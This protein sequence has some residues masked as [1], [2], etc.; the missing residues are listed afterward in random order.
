MSKILTPDE[1]RA[2]ARHIYELVPEIIPTEINRTLVSEWAEKNR[3]LTEGPFQG[4]FTFEYT[5]YLVEIA[6][7]LSPSCEEVREV[8]FMKP[9]RIGATVSVGENWIGATID[10]FPCDMGYI[11]S[12]GAMAEIQMQT[13][14]DALINESGIAHKIGETKKRAGQKKSG[15]KTVLKQFPSGSLLAGGPNSSFFKRS[16]GFKFLNVTEV[17]GFADDIGKEGDP[18]GLFRRRCGAFQNDYKILWES[19]PKLDHNSKIKRLYNEG[20]KRKF[21]VPCK[22]CGHEQ[23]LKWGD[24]DKP[25]GLKFEKDDDDR[26]IEGSV[27][28]E[29]EEC[30]G[31]W[32]NSDKDY[33]LKRGYWKATAV[34]RKP[35]VR[36]Y[37]INALYSPI[38]FVSWETGVMEFLEIKHNGFPALEFQ[39][40]VN[41]FLGEPFEDRGERPKIE[42]VMSRKKDYHVDTLPEWADPLF[43]TLGADVQKDRIEC[44]IVAWC[45]DF[46]SF[47]IN[48]HVIPGEA[49]NIND[50]CWDKLKQI[51]EAE[52][53]GMKIS[54][55]GIDSGYETN[56]VYSFCD[57]FARG[58]YP[59]MGSEQRTKDREVIKFFTIQGF[60]CPRVDINTVR[61]KDDLYMNLA[62]GMRE[63]GSFPAGYMHF[64]IEYDRKYFNMLTAENVVFDQKTKKKKYIAG[65]RRNESTDTRVYN[66]SLVHAYRQAI[67]DQLK[68]EEKME[69]DERLVFDN[70]WLYIK[71]K[72]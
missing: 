18:I 22:H 33:F 67:E 26:L 8:A 36:S 42:A 11:T 56:T 45:K 40:W 62:K 52:H 63:D 5:P 58:V 65:S 19:S 20:D 68:A 50:E 35:H 69:E 54:L 2:A 49:K 13:R 10:A 1:I 27:Y 70:F 53:C 14:I 59:V 25:G 55:S 60:N 3:T 72:K 61:L 30:G 46:E 7:S 9:A 29:C 15:D 17:D 28:Y 57:S 47:S 31:H 21:F 66:S 12:D 16:V 41:T 39:V 71:A 43:L 32:T 51:I 6:D 4:P 34:P 48:Y 64:P 37:H 44:E 24:K 38:G 23:F